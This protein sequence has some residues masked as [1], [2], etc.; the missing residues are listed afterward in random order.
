MI[1]L[2]LWNMQH[3]GD[4]VP[5]HAV[6]E[7]R[8]LGHLPTQAADEDGSG[9]AM[10]PWTGYGAVRTGLWGGRNFIAKLA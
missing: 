4:P 8:G 5:M 9:R 10:P 6:V 7:A 1:M 2:M 3:S